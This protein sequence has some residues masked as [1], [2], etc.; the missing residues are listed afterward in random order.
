MNKRDLM[1]ARNFKTWT[2]SNRYKEQPAPKHQ[3]SVD[4]FIKNGG[5]II[6]CDGVKLSPGN[7]A[8]PHISNG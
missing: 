7:P 5:R 3:Q 2:I 6:R 8:S 4:D 1:K